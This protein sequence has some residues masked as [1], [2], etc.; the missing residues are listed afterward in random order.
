M[1]KILLVLH[2][3]NF[4]ETAFDFISRLNERSPLLLTGFVLPEIPRIE[5]WAAYSAASA[6]NLRDTTA[7]DN[8]KALE[9]KCRDGHIEYRIHQGS[10]ELGMP[11]IIKET[12][13]AD[14][15]VASPEAFYKEGNDSAYRSL[16]Q[17]MQHSECPVL[18]IPDGSRFPEQLIFAYDGSESSLFAIKQF[19]Y[20]F[21]ELRTLHTVII[22]MDKDG[23]D[24]PYKEEVELW[25][26]GYFPRCSFVTL[27]YEAAQYFGSEAN[28]YSTLV[29]TGSFGRTALSQWI[30][31]SFAEELISKYHLLLFSG[32]KG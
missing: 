9:E 24:I 29:V 22:H 20:L 13:F 19:T 31:P 25:V 17:V 5:N 18:V 26:K 8:T 21:P 1:K 10:T 12:R 14:L 7:E 4:P 11:Q 32:H 28:P 16:R 6:G 2:G 23:I 3:D 15:L 27:N 30:H